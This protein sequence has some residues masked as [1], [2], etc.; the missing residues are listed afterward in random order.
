MD[1][2]I[3]NTTLPVASDKTPCL[4]NAKLMYLN[5]VAAYFILLI[6][7]ICVLWQHYTVYLIAAIATP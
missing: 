3:L 1:I 7:E 6:T 4:H 2:F 5:G